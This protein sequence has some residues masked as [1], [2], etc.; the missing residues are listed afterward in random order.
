M[1]DI[2][3]IFI[4]VIPPVAH[5]WF[6]EDKYARL[7][8]PNAA[9][10]IS[11]ITHGL[12][13]NVMLTLCPLRGETCSFPLN[14]CGFVTRK[15]VPLDDFQGKT[16]KGDTTSAWDF[17]EAHSWNTV[18][19]LWGSPTAIRSCCVW[20]ILLT[21]PAEVP[22]PIDMRKK[23]Q[24]IPAFKSAQWAARYHGRETTYP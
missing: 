18:T 10:T 19:M 24:M 13:C 8:I 9:L 20:V 7:D 6:P 15:E 23:L 21:A 2:T 12:F 14:L 11:P 5:Q 1:L 17:W 22:V 3:E 16:I 4:P